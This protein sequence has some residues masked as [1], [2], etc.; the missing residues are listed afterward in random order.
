MLPLTRGMRP[1]DHGNDNVGTL[2][3]RHPHAHL[4]EANASIEA[5]IHDWRRQ[6]TDK[7]TLGLSKL[8][9]LSPTGAEKIIDLQ[10]TAPGTYTH[11]LEVAFGDLYQRTNLDSAI[12]GL[13]FYGRSIG[14]LGASGAAVITSFTPVAIGLLGIPLL[15]E[16]PDGV[17]WI[18]IALV[19]A[20]VAFASVGPSREK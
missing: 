6:M 18:G 17:G 9:E 8:K 12:A 13:Y 2:A 20:G 3:I 14:K 5:H 1:G 7:R 16:F 19:S 11:V 10:D 4:G 15:G